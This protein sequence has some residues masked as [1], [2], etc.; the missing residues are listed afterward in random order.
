[1]TLHAWAA[2]TADSKNEKNVHDKTDAIQKAME[3][4]KA[5]SSKMSKSVLMNMSDNSAAKIGQIAFCAWRDDARTSRKVREFETRKS[6][7]DQK[8]SFMRVTQKAKATLV[9][10]LS[11]SR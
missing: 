4:M 7:S 3:D 11:A 5:K 1:M 10:G 9:K 2:C 6:I 8:M